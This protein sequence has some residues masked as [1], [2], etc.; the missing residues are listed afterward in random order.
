[1]PG[2]CMRLVRSNYSVDLERR[3]KFVLGINLREITW[4]VQIAGLAGLA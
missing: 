3:T 4:T 2:D 1:M